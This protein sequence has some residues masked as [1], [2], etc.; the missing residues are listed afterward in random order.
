MDSWGNDTGTELVSKA[1]I[2]KDGQ[3]WCHGDRSLT[4]LS[5]TP[6][7]QEGGLPD[8]Q[9][10]HSDAAKIRRFSKTSNFF[11]ILKKTLITCPPDFSE[12]KFDYTK[13]YTKSRMLTPFILHEIKGKD[14]D[15]ISN[16]QIFRDIFCISEGRR[17][18]RGH[19]KVQLFP[20]SAK[21]SR[22]NFVYSF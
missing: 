12:S 15:L 18:E 9:N 8:S 4:S 21:F 10:Y 7:F 2:W 22:D 5:E 1:S 19:A 17:D 11:A 14:K 20:D 3:T 13:Y 16:F 6:L